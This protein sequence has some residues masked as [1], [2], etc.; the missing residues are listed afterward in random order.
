VVSRADVRV[1][2]GVVNLEDIFKAYGVSGEND[3]AG[4]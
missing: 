2:L 4:K 3:H 1:V